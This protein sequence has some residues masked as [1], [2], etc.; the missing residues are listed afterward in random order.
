VQRLLEAAAALQAMPHEQAVTE[1]RAIINAGHEG[2]GPIK[3]G[4]NFPL[5]LCRMLFEPLPGKT[6]PLPE[7]MRIEPDFAA[8]WPDEPLAIVDG[9]PFQVGTVISSAPSAASSAEFLELCLSEGQWSSRRYAP[10]DETK[11]AAALDKLLK[12]YEAKVPPGRVRDTFEQRLRDQSHTA[13]AASLPPPVEAN[14]LPEALIARCAATRGSPEGEG[15]RI[16][17]YLE[18]LAALQALPK[19]TA[20]AQLRWW[21]VLGRPTLPTALTQALDGNRNA[22]NAARLTA[23]LQDLA[24]RAASRSVN[25]E[26]QVIV[27]S[28]LLFEPKPSPLGPTLHLPALGRPSF[29]G[30]RDEYQAGRSEAFNGSFIF[31]GDIPFGVVGGYTLGGRREDALAYLDHCIANGAWTT[32][33]YMPVP[34]ATLDKMLDALLKSPRW[35]SP[36]TD[37]EKK[38]FAAQIEPVPP[39]TAA[40]VPPSPARP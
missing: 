7:G 23:S 19:E 14:A 12:L 37:R 40:A 6:L 35:K 33:R 27:L 21:A 29:I 8:D 36:L 3:E 11:I 15:F 4:G 1:L 25:Y 31:L 26:Q 5:K 9:I 16:S 2:S 17:A 34:Q 28:R 24:S 20:F 22:P 30:S 13:A 39:I 18:L 38:M 10:A 32:R